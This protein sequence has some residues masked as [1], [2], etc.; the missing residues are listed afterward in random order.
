[1][2][3]YTNLLKIKLFDKLDISSRLIKSSKIMYD[4]SLSVD[5]Y[6]VRKIIKEKLFNTLSGPTDYYCLKFLEKKGP[7]RLLDLGCG[8]GAFFGCEII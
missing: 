7:M 3:K 1:M 5:E 6:D 8:A 2:I 4:T